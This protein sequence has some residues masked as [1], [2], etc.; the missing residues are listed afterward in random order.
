LF[1]LCL[2][3]IFSLAPYGLFVTLQYLY[4]NV[5]KDTGCAAAKKLSGVLH[6]LQVNNKLYIH[7]IQG[8]RKSLT[9]KQKHAKKSKT[10]DLQQRKEFERS[11]VLW[12]PRK[13]R[14]AKARESVRKAEDKAE[15]LEE[16]RQNS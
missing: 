16:V 5:V 1:Y 3:A 15:N 12:S 14:E 13:V 7:K 10:L 11:A 4:N 6:S 8:L 9:T 2:L